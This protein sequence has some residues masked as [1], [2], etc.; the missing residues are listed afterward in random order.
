ME[1]AEFNL[2]ELEKKQTA[3]KNPTVCPFVCFFHPGLSGAVFMNSKI[4]GKAG[5]NHRR[6]GP[7]RGAPGREGG[8]R[9]AV[10]QPRGVGPGH[11]LHGVAGDS[12]GVAI[13]GEIRPA[14]DVA[15]R[16]ETSPPL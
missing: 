12:C 5:Q 10:D 1:D 8:L 7:G 9:G 4:P 6:L 13:G 11:G 15:S 2:K 3:G 16:P 14:G